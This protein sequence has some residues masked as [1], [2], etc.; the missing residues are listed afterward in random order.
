LQELSRLRDLLRYPY[1][2]IEQ[3]TSGTFPLLYI[4]DLL[5]WV[6][7][8]AIKSHDLTDMV[9]V[10]INRLISMQTT[11]GGF[12][13]W[14]GH[15]E[16]TLWGTAYVTHLL[17]KAKELGYD[18]P[19]TTLADALDFLQEAVTSRRYTHDRKYGRNLVQS[20]PY[21]L[22]VLGLAG[23]HQ[24]GRLRQLASKPPNWREME[25]ENEFLLMLTYYLAGDRHAYERYTTRK[26]LLQPVSLSGRHY[27]GT[28]WSGLRTDAMRL[29][30]AED[31]W[32]GEVTLETLAQKVAITMQSRRYLS[33]QELSW[34]ISALGKRAQQYRGVGITG[35]ELQLDG[36]TIEPT[37]RHKEAP[38]WTLSG[39][40]FTE[41][42]LKITHTSDKPPLVYIKV[43][44]YVQDF[45]ALSTRDVPFALSRRYLNLRGEPIGARVLAQGELAVVE[46]TLDSSA[47]EEIPNIAVVDR[48]PAGLEIENSRLG[49]GRNLEW[50]PEEGI[51]ELDYVDLRD[52]RLQLFGTLP[53]RGHGHGIT[54]RR[55]YYVVRAVTP[56]AFTAPPAVLEV[57]YDPE[58]VYYTPYER[59]T[60]DA[61]SPSP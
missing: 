32:P 3:T 59:V 2:C 14:P 49:R 17:L 44:G 6:D 16:P 40:P 55:F 22:Y 47:A 24:Q 37:V 33:T 8:D 25:T 20:E 19:A 39:Y 9:Y 28:F 48:L 42:R 41:Q 46:L 60:I 54:T 1:G 31:V 35:V 50:L 23:R 53:R 13:Y 36:Q 26:H 29:S 7:P 27:S 5:E 57:M 61:S 56:G 34:S 43:H 11:S 38:I 18:V 15:N 58:K 12:G 52:D 4:S 10:G 45:A 30:L 21:M 51:F